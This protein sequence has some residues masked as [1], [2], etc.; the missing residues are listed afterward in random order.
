MDSWRDEELRRRVRWR[1]RVGPTGRSATP[2]LPCSTRQCPTRFHGASLSLRDTSTVVR[3]IH[4][5]GVQTG[6][7]HTYTRADCSGDLLSARMALDAAEQLLQAQRQETSEV[8]RAHMVGRGACALSN[9]ILVRAPRAL[10]PGALY[11]ACACAGACRIAKLP[12][13]AGE[14]CRRCAALLILPQPCART[15]CRVSQPPSGRGHRVRGGAGPS[16][17]HE[18]ESWRDRLHRMKETRPCVLWC[19]HH[20]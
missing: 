12:P 4:T 14:L 9:D 20:W 6:S 7:A 13:V 15:P 19:T 17:P 16:T 3:V 2:C 11:T 10:W 1:G 5:R 18:R 8:Q